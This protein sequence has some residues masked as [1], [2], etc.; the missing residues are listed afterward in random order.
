MTSAAEGDRRVGETVPIP[1]LSDFQHVLPSLACH[2][3]GS[4]AA[5]PDN[6]GTMKAG[7]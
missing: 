7:C 3:R 1:T 6:D 4:L 5:G 2:R